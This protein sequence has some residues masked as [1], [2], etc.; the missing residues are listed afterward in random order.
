MKTRDDFLQRLREDPAY[1][2]ALGQ[3]KSAAERKA[4]SS[5][6]E[7]FVGSAAEILLPA[8]DRAKNDPEFARQLAKALTEHQ[9]VV[10][11]Q[12]PVSG[13]KP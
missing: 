2:A 11:K 8:L 13:S 1:R 9:S 6:V 10:S 12:S 5:L 3:A 4:I 7:E